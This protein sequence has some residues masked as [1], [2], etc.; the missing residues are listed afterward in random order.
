MDIALAAN[1]G[2]ADEICQQRI[3]QHHIALASSKSIVDNVG[4][5][6]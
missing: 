3:V 4:T 2:I 6:I 5:K 1:Q